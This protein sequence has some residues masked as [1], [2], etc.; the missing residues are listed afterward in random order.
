MTETRKPHSR[1]WGI[2][3]LIKDYFKD[4]E[5]VAVYFFGSTAAGAEISSRKSIIFY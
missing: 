5:D 2:E 1:D 4:R 3:N